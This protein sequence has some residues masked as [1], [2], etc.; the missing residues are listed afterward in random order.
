MNTFNKTIA[1]IVLDNSPSV[2]EN[3]I[4]PMANGEFVVIIENKHKDG[5]A[6]STFEIF[7]LDKG[8]HAS[9]ITENKYENLSGW[10]FE[11]TEEETPNA[12]TFLWITDEEGTRAFLEDLLEPAS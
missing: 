11:L 1:G 12:A 7:G 5:T 8:L 10:S 6:K 3:I 2:A 9:S 4:N